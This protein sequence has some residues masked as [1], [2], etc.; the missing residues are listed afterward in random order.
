VR[1]RTPRQHAAEHL[2]IAVDAVRA[3]AAGSVEIRLTTLNPQF[4]A[5]ADA[6]RAALPGV[7]VLDD[8]HRESGRHYYRGFCFKLYHVDVGRRL[9]I[10]DGGFVHWTQ[11]MLA[12]RKERLLISGIGVERLALLSQRRE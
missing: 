8:P 1:H 9:E 11:A 10:G 7:D 12:D 4:D 6:I 5:V 2:K 3:C